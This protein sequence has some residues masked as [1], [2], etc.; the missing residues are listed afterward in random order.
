MRD[1]KFRQALKNYVDECE[2]DDDIILLENHSYDK[3]IIGITED[4]RVVYD[5]EAMIEEFAE[6]EDCSIEEAQ[7]WVDYN[8]MR[9]I[10]YF[11]P[12]RPIVINFV[13]E[14][15]IDQYLGVGDDNV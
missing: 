7:E 12:S 11:G 10:P 4:N 8:T 3:S 9:A 2:I 13:K 5:Y 15:L 1:E 6:D 14:D